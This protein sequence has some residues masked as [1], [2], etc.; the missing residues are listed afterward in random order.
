MTRR[1]AAQGLMMTLD[2]TVISEVLL[3]PRPGFISRTKST[4]ISSGVAL[5]TQLEE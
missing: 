5:M 3:G 2:S 4:T 1:F